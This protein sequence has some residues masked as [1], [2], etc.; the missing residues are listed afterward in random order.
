MVTRTRLTYVIRTLPVLL[1]FVTLLYLS[2]RIIVIV[3]SGVFDAWGEA[4]TMPPPPPMREF[5]NC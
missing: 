2:T 5:V 3:R 1:L 4:I